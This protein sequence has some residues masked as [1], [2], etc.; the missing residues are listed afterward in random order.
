MSGTGGFFQRLGRDS[1][2]PLD[3]ALSGWGADNMR[4]PA[5]TGLLGRSAEEA[6]TAPGLRP[7]RASFELFRPARMV[8]T[9]TRTR[10]VRT[11][12]RLTLVD[13][14][15]IQS[16]MVVARA[17]VLF[18][19]TAAEPHGHVW[20]PGCAVP[21]PAEAVAA[22]DEGRSYFSGDAWTGA[23]ADHHNDRPKTVW[24][25]PLTVVKG[26]PPTPFEAVA[27]ASDITSLAVH[28]GD[29]GV[30]FI[31]ADVSITLARL[32]LSVG[33]GISVSHRSSDSGVSVGSAVL[34]DR[35]GPL[36]TSSVV[37]LANARNAVVPGQHLAHL[38][39]AR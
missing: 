32:P 14:E 21:P 27:A 35:S 16:A 22:D 2:A 10:V 3:A 12:G 9:T 24:Q 36:G 1:Y 31:N 34:F 28:W 18:V 37:A 4:G 5:L 33:L 8:R 13:S 20:T 26:S 25:Q 29:R 23:A 38:D 6:C 11:G 19:A 39:D 30:E 7:A 15:L 17:H